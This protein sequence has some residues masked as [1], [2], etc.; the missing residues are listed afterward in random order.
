M[1]TLATATDEV[2]LAQRS[3]G[4][5]LAVILAGHNGSGKSTMWHKHLSPSFQIPL[6]NADRMMLSI[7]PEPEGSGKLV[8]WAQRL[9]DTDTNWMQVSQKGV[10][11]FVGQAMAR[12]VPFAMET[13]FSY[14]DERPDG[15]V[16]SKIDLIEQM[17][18]SGYFVL[19]FFVGLS[20]VQLSIARVQTRIHQGGH[21]V[22]HGKLVDRFPRTQNAIRV[23]ASVADATIFA[24]NS[25]GLRQAFTVCR[26]Q[27]RSHQAFD[28]RDGPAHRVPAEIEEWLRVVS[29]RL[30]A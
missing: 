1:T 18:Q 21:A 7:L 26:V 28:I 30:A 12:G 25:R 6:V 13:V 8:K 19:L 3:S 16:R 5:P 15:T 29:P 20:N 27:I 10:E 11:A 24:D 2:Q 23:A 22:E 9:R 4:K 14:W 17:Q